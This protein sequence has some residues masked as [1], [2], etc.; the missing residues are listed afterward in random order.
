MPVT[1][2]VSAPGNVQRND[3]A[4]WAA[5]PDVP[6]GVRREK[7]HFV[8]P[9]LEIVAGTGAQVP[10]SVEEPEEMTED[11]EVIRLELESTPL[12]LDVIAEERGITLDE[13][14]ITTMLLLLGI[15]VEEEDRISSE[16]EDTMTLLETACSSEAAQAASAR[17][18]SMEVF[19]S[20]SFL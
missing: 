7:V 8:D 19:L 3:A 11:E 13:L 14:G 2:S 12:E 6:A 5:I 1:D 4:N 10:V 17:Q 9:P 16:E 15:T 18:A 20:T